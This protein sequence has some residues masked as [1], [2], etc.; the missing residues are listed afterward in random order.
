MKR[1]ELL[2]GLGALGVVG[3]GAA[4]QSGALDFED[5]QS[6]SGGDADGIDPVELER[7]DAPGSSPGTEIVPEQGRVTYLT[8]FATWCTICQR[9]MDPL[10][11]AA[12]EVDD[13]VQFISVTNEPVGATVEPAEVVDWWEE[14]DGS[15]PVARDE[16]LELTQQ[17]DAPGVPYSVV[18]DADNRIVWS[19][20]GY[21][22][23]DTILEH[24]REA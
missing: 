18:F 14:H 3:T 23:S 7:F 24:I 17:V 2:A 5:L 13:D 16:D 4:Y 11:E 19:D 9:K 12:A 8:L 21:K 10:G 6:D 20:S 1:R 15:W 22:G